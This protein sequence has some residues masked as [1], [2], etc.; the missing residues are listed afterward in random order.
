MARTKKETATTTTTTTVNATT[1]KN[2]GK[3][4]VDTMA[5]TTKKEATKSATKSATTKKAET[6]KKALYGY[7]SNKKEAWISRSFKEIRKDGT[8]YGMKK[9]AVTLPKNV[10]EGK[11]NG[12]VQAV[13]GKAIELEIAFL[14]GKIVSA[15]KKIESVKKSKKLDEA[16]KQEKIDKLNSDIESYKLQKNV[17][18]KARRSEKFQAGQTYPRFVELLAC[19]VLGQPLSV[20]LGTFKEKMRGYSVYLDKAIENH[21]NKQDKIMS[22]EEE[23]ALIDVKRTL[24]ES[25]KSIEEKT[26]WTSEFKLSVSNKDIETFYK[27]RYSGYTKDYD[28]NDRYEREKD[29]FLNKEI[30]KWYLSKIKFECG[31]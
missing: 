8:F 31:K 1:T 9:I 22:K 19:A 27:I 14:S 2:E 26:E 3:K 21:M 11:E 15:T 20:E 17:L 28:L 24:K 10:V 4:E 13:Q 16:K 30:C 23:E 12:L 25:M 18:L 29:A 6:K 7:D 5:T